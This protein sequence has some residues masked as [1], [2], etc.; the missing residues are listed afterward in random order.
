LFK[1][2]PPAPLQKLVDLFSGLPESE[3]RELLIHYAAGSSRFA[4]QEGEAFEIEDLRKDEECTDTVGIH[5]RLRDGRCQFWIS[6]GPEVQTLTRALTSVLAEGLSGA[7]PGEIMAVPESVID[8][9][10][11][12]TLV[13]LRSRTAYYV[14][15]RF[16]EA[17]RPLVEPARDD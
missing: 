8:R 16:K 15:R 9:I 12:E 2:M 11:G 17:V 14:L 3:R 4:P 13:R 1:F 10:V 7:T 6:L 5:V